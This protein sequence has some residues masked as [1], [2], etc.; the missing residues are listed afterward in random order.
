MEMWTRGICG[1][2]SGG[3]DQHVEIFE[4]RGAIDGGEQSA[5]ALPALGERECTEYCR[6]ESWLA[7]SEYLVR[8]SNRSAVYVFAD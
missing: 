8:R 5:S 6:R 4:N 7:Q 3:L 1:V 2:G